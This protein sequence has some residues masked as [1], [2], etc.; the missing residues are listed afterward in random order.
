[1]I[2]SFVVVDSLLAVDCSFVGGCVFFI[3][4][5]GGGIWYDYVHGCS[6]IFSYVHIAGGG[7]D[8]SIAH[9]HSSLSSWVCRAR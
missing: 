7:V 6:A 1:M 5:S 9:F 8:Y 4:G 2:C 3:F